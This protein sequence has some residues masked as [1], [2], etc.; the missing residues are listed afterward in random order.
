VKSIEEYDNDTISCSDYSVV[1][2]GMP[3]DVTKDELQKQL[4]AFYEGLNP[5]SIPAKWRRPF[6]VAKLNVGK[7]FYLHE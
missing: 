2:E 1:M 7:P 4:D 3:L 5:D 6:K